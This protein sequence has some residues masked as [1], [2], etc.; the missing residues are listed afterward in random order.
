MLRNEAHQ[1]RTLFSAFY[2]LRKVIESIPQTRSPT[3]QHCYTSLQGKAPI[4]QICENLNAASLSPAP[5]MLDWIPMDIIEMTLEIQ[6]IADKMIP[7]TALPQTPFVTLLTAFG[8]PFARL[9]IP[10]EAAFYQSPTGRIISVFSRQAQDAMQVFRQNHNAVNT[11]RVFYFYL[12]KSRSQD[13][14]P[15]NQQPIFLLAPKL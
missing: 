14:N 1:S 15:V 3:N 6:L 5:A 7:K 11:E 12:G 8:N 4:E 2:E 13:I 10:G 9:N